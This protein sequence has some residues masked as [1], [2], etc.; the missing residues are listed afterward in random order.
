VIGKVSAAYA[1]R[2]GN[3]AA[4]NYGPPG[5]NRRLKIERSPISFRALAA[6]PFDMHCLSW[7]FP[8]GPNHGRRATVSIWTVAGRLKELPIAGDPKRLMLLQT[9]RV[10]ESDLVYVDHKWFLHATVDAPEA[11]LKQPANGFLGVDM[12]IVN[13]ATTSTGKKASGARLNRYRK[14]QA[15]LR[16][17]LQVKKTSS[18]RRLLKKR[19]RKESRYATDVNH[20]ISK[21]IV[22]EAERTGHGIAIEQLG[23][24]RDRVRLRKP[25]RPRCI[26]GRLRSSVRFWLIRPNKPVWHSSRWT[27]HIRRRRAVHA[28]GSTNGIAALKRLSSVAGV[29]SLGTPTTTQRLTSQ[30]AVSNVG[31]KSCVQTQRLPWQPARAEAASLSAARP[32]DRE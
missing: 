14:R 18:A 19:R 29:A 24:I 21:R 3:I 27:P 22:A 7:R 28:A 16:K 9:R 8:D 20:Q 1:S 12:G 11:P 26:R 23:G 6:Q 17:R 4:G 25:Q 2:R 32:L 5:S 13:I 10:T 31:A 30:P 15:R